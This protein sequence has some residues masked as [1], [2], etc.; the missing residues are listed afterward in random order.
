MSVPSNSYNRP[1]RTRDD[2]KDRPNKV[3]RMLSGLTISS[4]SRAMRGLGGQQPP[5]HYAGG[6]PM[7]PGYY[8]GP[9]PPYPGRVAMPGYEETF[10]PI[11]HRR[12]VPIRADFVAQRRIAFNSGGKPGVRVVDFLKNPASLDYHDNNSVFR[13]LDLKGAS[14]M[15]WLF[16]WPGY[17]S[18][19]FQEQPLSVMFST[20]GQ[21]AR[22]ICGNLAACL[23]PS[24]YLSKSDRT[25]LVG[26]SDGQIQ[27]NNIWL[28]SVSIGQLN[29][30]GTNTWIAE[31]E[32]SAHGPRPLREDQRAVEFY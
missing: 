18:Q 15:R 22:I 16:C 19:L 25:W 30:T 9:I 29:S 32:V 24:R 17:Q 28:L 27:F 5:P 3:T 14:S 13:E 7:P 23:A 1:K 12:Q 4:T 2:E 8:D 21:I 20:I 31:F 11:W 10:K 26:S 6:F